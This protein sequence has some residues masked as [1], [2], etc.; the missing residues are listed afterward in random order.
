MNRKRLEPNPARRGPHAEASPR[1]A[2]RRGRHLHA[3]SRADEDL[4]MR[5]MTA[6]YQGIQTYKGE[7]HVAA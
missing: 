6:W 7:R 3:A 4:G 2:T 5:W 1:V